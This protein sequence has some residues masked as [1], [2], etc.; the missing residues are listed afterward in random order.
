MKTNTLIDSFLAYCARNRSAATLLFYRSRLRRFREAYN[1]RDFDTLTALEIDEH[2]ALAGAGMSG[3]TRHHN[4]LALERLQK[5][6][7]Q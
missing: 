4:A 7:G 3:S 2:L 5:L 1:L 6:V